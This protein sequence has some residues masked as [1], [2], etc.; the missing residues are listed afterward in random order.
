MS[1]RIDH[2]T[3]AESPLSTFFCHFYFCIQI[4]LSC[5]QFQSQSKPSAQCSPPSLF[6]SMLGCHGRLQRLYLH[7]QH[8]LIQRTRAGE[9]DKLFCEYGYRVFLTLLFLC[10]CSCHM[11]ALHLSYHL[12]SITT[13]LR[14]RDKIEQQK[15]IN[16][17]NI[18]V[19]I[20]MDY[21]YDF[22]IKIV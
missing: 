20:M 17:C 5:H 10:E 7:A 16:E 4:Q 3:Y 9:Q 22:V 18:F 11:L 21:F 13:Y 6:L 15:K 14:L 2:S 12:L 8:C 1:C 19:N